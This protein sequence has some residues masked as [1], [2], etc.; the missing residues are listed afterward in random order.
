MGKLYIRE[1]NPSDYKRVEEIY[2]SNRQFLLTH[3]GVEAVD[4]EFI[5]DEAETM[6]KIGFRSCVIVSEETQTVQGVL[7]YKPDDEVYLSLLMLSAELQGRGIGKEIYALFES[8]MRKEKRASIRIDVVNDYPGN[9]VPF[10][11]KLGFVDNESITLEWGNKKSSAIVMS[12]R[13]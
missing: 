7:D 13:I 9:V 3:L 4:E 2:N 6:E 12:K 5:S 11:E 10:W 8:K 1:L